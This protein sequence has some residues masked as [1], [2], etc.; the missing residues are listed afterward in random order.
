LPLWDFL[1][2]GADGS[3]MPIGTPLTEEQMNKL[4][5]N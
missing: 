1:K 5:D 3:H 2:T 4:I